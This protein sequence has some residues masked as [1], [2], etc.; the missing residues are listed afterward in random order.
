M[1]YRGRV[2]GGVVVLEKPGVLPEGTSVSVAPVMG[3]R[4]AAKR[5]RGEPWRSLLRHAGK[6][7]DLPP[8]LAE[9]HDHYIH[10]RPKR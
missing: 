8:D 10:G 2:S 9:N 6:G 1:T 3:G 4:K 7:R 5:K